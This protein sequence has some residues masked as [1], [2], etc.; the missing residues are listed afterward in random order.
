MMTC[1]NVQHLFHQFI[2]GELSPSMTAEVHAHLLQCPACQRDV[3]AARASADVITKD[4]SEPILKPGFASQVV[5]AMMEQRP[6]TVQFDARPARRFHWQKYAVVGSL[7]AAAAAVLLFVVLWPS[8]P[9]DQR[10]KMVLGVSVVDAAGVSQV[11]DPTVD[12]VSDARD[13]ARSLNQLLKISADQAGEG[14]RRGLERLGKVA[15]K[16]GDPSF[17]DIFLQPFDAILVTPPANTTDT[18]VVRF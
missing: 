10:D 17:M 15:P 18:E 12:A 3:E 16:D 8:P 11:M 6:Q 9:A 4:Q 7:P 1:R 14:V 2:D 13:A 5:A